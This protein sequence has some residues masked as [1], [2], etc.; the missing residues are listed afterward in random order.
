VNKSIIWL[1]HQVREKILHAENKLI[2]FS[3]KD[4]P[5]FCVIALLFM[6]PGGRGAV[7]SPF[8]DNRSDSFAN[9]SFT[10]RSQMV[11]VL[12]SSIRYW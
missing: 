8:Y 6:S 3:S 9:H 4:E 5:K 12:L 7:I 10:A 2:E 11:F 1:S